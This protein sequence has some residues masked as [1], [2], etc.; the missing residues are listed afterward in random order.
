MSNL[1]K[2][3]K[4]VEDLT[5]RDESLLEKVQHLDILEELFRKISP[6]YCNY[7]R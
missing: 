1:E 3:R 4:L 7:G 2:I 5:I 6:S